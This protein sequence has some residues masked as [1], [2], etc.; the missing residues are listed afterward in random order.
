M[1]NW[2]N[3]RGLNRFLNLAKGKLESNKKTVVIALLSFITL[4]SLGYLDIFNEAHGTEEN[5][6]SETLQANI[7]DNHSAALVKESQLLL[8]TT[9]SEL[10]KLGQIK[11]DIDS[12]L[13]IKF[14]GY[15]V[16][17]NGRILAVFKTRKEADN[18][19]REIMNPYL[20][21]EESEERVIDDI[22]FKEDVSIGEIYTNISAFNTYEEVIYYITRGTDEVKI[23]RIEKGENYWVI[24]E[25]YK[26]TSDDLEKANP[27]VQPERLQIG[28][29]ISLVVPKPFLTVVTTEKTEYIEPIKYET[30]YEDTSVLY[31]EEYRVK[32]SGSNG[33]SHIEAKI[34][35]E[36][37]IEVDKEILKETITK[38]PTTEIILKG[39]KVPPPKIGTGTLSNP[40]SRGYIT[41]PFGSRWGKRHEGIDIGMPT[42]TTVKAADGGKVTF[43]GWRGAYGYLVIINHGANME[44]Y[45][46]HNSK[47]Q[48]K[49]G[50]K[51]FK[52]QTIAS[53]GNTG[54]S[55]GPHLHFEVRKNGTPLNPIKY[56]N[57]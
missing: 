14:K 26:V 36:N 53:S 45:Y 25:K 54:R 42:G 19:L 13:K 41:S 47:L 28:Q 37:G 32:R 3:F 40:T 11:K 52:G 56:I 12:I 7:I 33:E 23:H 22:R 31:K 57:Y 2:K 15:A 1:M 29:E 16:S 4:F 43:A 9:E 49:N 20:E 55:T 6:L 18:L 5:K 35:K 44:T 21:S 38:E 24:A 51:V 8:S 34:I 39:T 30:E 27:E 46:A 17:A 10:K 48:V 50:E